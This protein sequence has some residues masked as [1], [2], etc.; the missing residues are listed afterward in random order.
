MEERS[1]TGI[2]PAIQESYALKAAIAGIVC[3]IVSAFLNPF[4]VTKIRLQNQRKTVGC[5]GKLVYDGLFRGIVKIFQDEGLAGLGKGVQASMLRE[6]S[7]SSVRIGAYE[8]IR[9]ILSSNKDT[10][11]ASPAIK[12][13]SALVSGGVGAA[14]ANPFDLVKTRF[15]AHLPGQ[16]PPYTSTL[17]AFPS[18]IRSE[19]ISGLYKGWP[20]TSA[21]AAILTS[22]QLGSYDTIKNNVLIGFF[23][24]ENGFSLHLAA[25]MS[26]GL[27]TTTAANPGRQSPWNAAF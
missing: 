11:N 24:L 4:D 1:N 8:P 5:N 14:I 13:F 9:F 27:I 10:I 22:A 21:R 16:L 20:V 7:Y 12:F 25:S 15:Q 19:G 17:A 26:S 6:I 2:S 23:G 3:S 18:I